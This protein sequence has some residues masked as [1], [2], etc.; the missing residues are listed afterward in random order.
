MLIKIEKIQ[1]KDLKTLSC[2]YC[3][4]NVVGTD[5]LGD[6]ATGYIHIRCLASQVKHALRN[7]GKKNKK[8]IE[9]DE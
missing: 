4:Q 1:G 6:D 2:Y 7:A 3:K 8:E 9:M 5:L